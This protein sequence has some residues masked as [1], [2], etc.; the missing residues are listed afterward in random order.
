MRAAAAL[1]VIAFVWGCSSPTNR[2]MYDQTPLP[3]LK[4]QISTVPEPNAAGQIA[5]DA[6]IRVTMDDYPDPDTATFGPILL[7]SGTASFDVT[8]HV[9]LVGRAIEVRPRGLLAP[10][11]EYELVLSS[12]LRALS[13]RKNGTTLAATLTV[14]DEVTPSP[15]PSPA[16]VWDTQ[17]DCPGA[18]NARCDIT[19]CAPACHAPM[20]CSINTRNPTIALDLTGDPADPKL[21]LIG[22]PSVLMAGTDQPLLRVKPGD[23]ARSVLLRK[24]LGGDPHADSSDPPTANLGV[25]GR[26]MP[27]YEL[28]CPVSGQT[29]GTPDQVYWTEPQLR[30]IQDWI[31]QGALV[32]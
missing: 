4:L 15:S 21:G 24:L 10:Q 8:M 19:S 16:V 30:L 11:T 31:D 23:A 1:L 6:V 7:R 26:R 2:P 22:V 13:G 9:D 27:L 17:A 32:N 29:L 14:G 5:R 18:N 25:R 12:D 28:V 20:G 3:P